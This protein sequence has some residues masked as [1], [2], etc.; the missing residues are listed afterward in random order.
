MNRNE[1]QKRR[2]IKGAFEQLN[3]IEQLLNK[4]DAKLMLDQ[5]KAA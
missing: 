4:I 1:L 2:L 3:K 5:K